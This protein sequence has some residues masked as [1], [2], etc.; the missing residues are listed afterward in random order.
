MSNSKDTRYFSHDYNSRNDIKIRKLILK[1][2]QTGYGIFWS[3][4]ED[5]YN[6]AN[7]LPT[8][9][10]LIADELKADVSMVK[11][12]ICDFQLFVISGELFG[13]SS[14]ESR[15]AARKKTSNDARDK[16]NA[17]WAKEREKQAL[18]ALAMQQHSTGNAIN[19]ETNK[20]IDTEIAATPPPI[21]SPQE[22]YS[23]PLSIAALKYISEECPTVAKMKSP[24]THKEANKLIDEFGKDVLKKYLNGFRC[25]GLA[26]H[27]RE[28]GEVH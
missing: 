7:A 6:N 18:E 15:I 8:D 27:L 17:R 11:S 2:G 16:A 22:D 25:T 4:V 13:S 5:L 12:V 3:I 1:H 28:R 19:K 21:T 20:K 23:T 24:L 10:E 14:V 26:V 9:Y